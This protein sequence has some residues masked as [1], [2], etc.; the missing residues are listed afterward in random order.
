MRFS[1]LLM[2]V[3]TMTF[4]SQIATA[5]ENCGCPIKCPRCD[6]VCK[7][8]VEKDNETHHCW[9]VEWKPICIP[10]VKFPWEPCCKTKCAKLKYVRTLKK[11]EYKCPTCKYTWNAVPKCCCG[12]CAGSDKGSSKSH[13]PQDVDDLKIPTPEISHLP[14]VLVAPVNANKVSRQ[15]ESKMNT[16]RSHI[17]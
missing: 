16:F 11:V 4:A 1:I 17:E 12:D 2:L 5:G 3:A 14:P 9:E 15:P 13:D 10:R 7:L 6:H 8:T